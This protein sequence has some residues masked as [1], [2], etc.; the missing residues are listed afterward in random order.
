MR[1]NVTWRPHP[2]CRKPHS[3]WGAPSEQGSEQ[4]V[5]NLI[6]QLVH[7]TKPDT[8][9]ETGTYL[10]A[11]AGAIA[12][13]L[14]SNT[15]GHLVTYENDAITALA[16]KHNLKW[17][18]D[19]VE[20]IAEAVTMENLPVSIDFAFLDSCMECREEEMQLVWPR[21]TLGGLVLIHDAAPERPPGRV[22]P[23]SPYGMLEFATPRGLNA[24]QK[25]W[26]QVT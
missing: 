24:F 1:E 11:T 18:E 16:A 12:Q 22:R 14:I 5:T 20:V 23:P 7:L 9:I 3:L 15:V 8:V 10:G 2:H 26:E 19:V 6:A 25:P 4:E 17:Y 21:I 13:A